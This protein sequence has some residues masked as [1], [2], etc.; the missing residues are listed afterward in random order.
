MELR[1]GLVEI[2]DDHGFIVVVDEFEFVFLVEAIHELGLALVRNILEGGVNG[3]LDQGIL[4]DLVLLDMLSPELED[5]ELVFADGFV[6][7]D[8]D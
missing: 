3:F 5:L 2:V 7:V 1:H 6:N 4:R 8:A